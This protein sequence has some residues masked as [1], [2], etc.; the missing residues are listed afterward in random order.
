M[1][2][3]PYNGE[4]EGSGLE[5]KLCLPTPILPCGNVPAGFKGY[6]VNFINQTDHNITSATG[7]GLRETLF[8]R[9]FGETQVYET[10]KDMISARSCIKHGAVSLDGGIIKENGII[11]LGYGYVSFYSCTLA[12]FLMIIKYFH[13]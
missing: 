8:Y 4:L 11:S 13:P 2:F 5:R 7:H 12:L 10:R 9:L 3:R 6:A 1:F